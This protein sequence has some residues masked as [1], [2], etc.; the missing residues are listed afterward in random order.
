MRTIF[1]PS[2]SNDHIH[3]DQLRPRRQRRAERKFYLVE[4]NIDEQRLVAAAPPQDERDAPR[5]S[6]ADLARCMP[7]YTVERARLLRNGMQEYLFRL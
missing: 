3:A 1:R 7:G 2:H 6:P 4:R 5:Y